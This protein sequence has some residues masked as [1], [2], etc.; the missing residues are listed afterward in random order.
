VRKCH[1]CNRA[2]SVVGKR[3]QRNGHGNIRRC[4]NK[5]QVENESHG[6]ECSKRLAENLRAIHEICDHGV[7]PVELDQDVPAVCGEA[8]K[9][10]DGDDSRD[11]AKGLESLRSR[12]ERS[13]ESS[14]SMQHELLTGKE[15]RCRL[16]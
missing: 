12:L 15:C 13:V 10:K 4:A 1:E 9:S 3:V 7:A 5:D 11:E 14:Y 16:R 6:E 8:A 2:Q